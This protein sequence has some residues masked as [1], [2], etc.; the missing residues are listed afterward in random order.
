MSSWEQTAM[1]MLSTTPAPQ[2]SEPPPSAPP[3]ANR[4][5]A[6]PPPSSPSSSAV[7][8]RTAQPEQVSPTLARATTPAM[9]ARAGGS[10]SGGGDD[11]YEEFLDRLRRDLLRE[12]EQIGDLLGETPW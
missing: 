6:A 4:P 10:G 8:A 3:P 12:R 2:A 5:P 11:G 7:I 1:Q 9:I